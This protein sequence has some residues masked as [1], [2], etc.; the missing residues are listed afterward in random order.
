[1]W[2]ASREA[3]GAPRFSLLPPEKTQRGKLREDRFSAF[4]VKIVL[5]SGEK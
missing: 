5:E 2:T 3:N 1:M 4:P